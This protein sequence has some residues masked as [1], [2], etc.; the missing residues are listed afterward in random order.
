MP[1]GHPEALAQR[2][3]RASALPAKAFAAPLILFTA[4]M[5]SN[6]A[7]SAEVSLEWDAVDDPRVA[8]YELHWG[9]ASG[10]Y[11]HLEQISGTT[12]TVQDLAEGSTYYFAV[13]A[14]AQA[15]ALCSA[16]SREISSTI[17][18]RPPTADF[19]VAKQNGALPLT[20]TFSDASSGAIDTY[21]WDFGDGSTSA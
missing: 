12:A 1:N 2:P 20:V 18:Y 3:R 15:A 7:T 9:S 19:V 17:A 21:A 13:R 14:C 11:E 10:V 6:S 4:S 16:F 8:F 5:L